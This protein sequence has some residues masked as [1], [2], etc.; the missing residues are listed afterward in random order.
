MASESMTSNSQLLQ[1][2]ETRCVT[3]NSYS[4]CVYI[5]CCSIDHNVVGTMCLHVPIYILFLCRYNVLVVERDYSSLAPSKWLSW[6]DLSISQGVGVLIRPISILASAEDGRTLIRTVTALSL[7]YQTC[8]VVLYHQ[9][10]NRSGKCMHMHVA[11]Y[12]HAC[13]L[14]M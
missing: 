5:S 4:M 9:D 12:V 14:C 2:L 13:Y 6:A 1:L 8:W 10:Q 11:T 3:V 7:Q